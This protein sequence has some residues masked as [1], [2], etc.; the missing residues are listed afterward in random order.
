MKSKDLAKFLA[1]SYVL[2]LRRSSHQPIANQAI[3]NLIRKPLLGLLFN[4]NCIYQHP[5]LFYPVFLRRLF[6]LL[7]NSLNQDMT[8]LYHQFF[9]DLT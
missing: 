7:T 3:V 4:Q 5:I 1:E 2:S 8:Y 6:P 9:Q